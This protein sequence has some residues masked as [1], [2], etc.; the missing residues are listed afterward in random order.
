MAIRKFETGGKPYYY[1]NNNQVFR[2]N[3]NGTSTL[4][5]FINGTTYNKYKDSPEFMKTLELAFN[6]Y[7]RRINNER[8]QLI[9]LSGKTK[10]VTIKGRGTYQ[11]PVEIFNK[12]IGA[13]KIANIDPKQGLAIAIKESSGYTDPKRINTQYRGSLPNHQW[14]YFKVPNQAGPSTIVSNWQY[15]NNSPYIGLLKGWENS[16]WDINRVSEDAKYQYKKHQTDYDKYDSNLDED[17]LVNMFKLPLNQINSNETTYPQTIKQYMQD[18]SYK[19]G[20]KL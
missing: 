15:F 17:I 2:K 13:A 11:V 6:R 16:G 10:P 18:M 12:I 5:P 20:G 7:G 14:R 9:S 4:F 8:K 1:V 3:S 19:F